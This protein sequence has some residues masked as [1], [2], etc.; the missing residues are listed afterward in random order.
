MGNIT[1]DLSRDACPYEDT[2][3]V[4]VHAKSRKRDF[5]DSLYDLGLTVSL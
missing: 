4:I 1:S 2:H 5:V 3:G